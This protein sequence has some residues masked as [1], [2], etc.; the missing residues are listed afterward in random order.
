MAGSGEGIQP[1]SSVFDEYA[2]EPQGSMP[3]SRPASRIASRILP[4]CSYG[5]HSSRPGAPAMPWRSVRTRSPAIV[6][7]P[8]WKKRTFSSS[9]PLS[10]S[11]ICHA[12]GPW[13]WKR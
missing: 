10:F 4:C 12:F 3:N 6:I 7:S 8:M 9:P 13:I 11:M 1:D 5:P 2:R